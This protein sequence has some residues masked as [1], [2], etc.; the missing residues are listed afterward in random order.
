MATSLPVIS[1][2]SG[3]GK[4]EGALTINHMTANCAL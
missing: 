3:G 1:G 4:G 2:K